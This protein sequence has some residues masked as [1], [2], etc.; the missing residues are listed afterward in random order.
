M[1]KIKKKALIIGASGFLGTKLVE[2]LSREYE[3]FG[4]HYLNPKNSTI[5]M[6]ITKSEQIK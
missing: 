1:I 4:T 2:T 3:V 6:D 5:Y